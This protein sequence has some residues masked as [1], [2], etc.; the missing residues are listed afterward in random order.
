[1]N[2]TTQTV[3]TGADGQPT[4][5]TEAGGAPAETLTELLKEFDTAAQSVESVAGASQEDVAVPDDLT[6][7]ALFRELHAVKRELTRRQRDELEA[8]ANAD[9]ERAVK[10]VGGELSDFPIKVSERI[11]RGM[12]NDL[13]ASDK[14]FMAAFN[15]RHEKPDV[16][17]RALKAVAR[18]IRA[19]LGSQADAALSEDRAAALAAVRGASTGA[20]KES[21][22]PALHKMNAREFEEY[23]RS[24]GR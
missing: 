8:A 3:T 7:E 11:V 10:A 22:V 5:G 2:D 6:P 15:A 21:A 14:R 4:A 17:A 23:K 13:A 18:E 20:P 24:L 16:W 12:L 9:V 1:M 19:D